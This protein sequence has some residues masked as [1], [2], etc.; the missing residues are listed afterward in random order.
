M[1]HF[2]LAVAVCVKPVTREHQD[3]GLTD[4]LVCLPRRVNCKSQSGAKTAR[5]GI[6]TI[7]QL[8]VA[9]NQSERPN[10]FYHVKALTTNNGEMLFRKLLYVLLGKSTVSF[11]L[12]V[13]MGLNARGLEENLWQLSALPIDSQNDSEGWATTSLV[14]KDRH[15]EYIIHWKGEGVDG[16]SLQFRHLEFRGALSAVL[17]TSVVD[18][19]FEDALDYTGSVELQASKLVQFNSAMQYIHIPRNI[20]R[21][22]LVE[23]A[24]RCSLIHALYDIV[25][26][27][28]A[29]PPLASSA[30]QNNGFGDMYSGSQN[31]EATWCVRVRR[32]G[33]SLCSEK[34]KRY[35]ARARS[36]KLEKEALKA[37][38]PLLLQFGGKVNLN[39]PDCKIYIFDGL[40]RTDKVLARRI[41]SGP[42]VSAIAPNTRI[43]VTNTPLCPVAAFLLCNVAGIRKIVS[44][45][46]PYVGSGAILLAAAMIQ[47]SCRSVGIEIAD[48]GYVNRDDILLDFDTRNLTRPLALLHGDSTNELM[49]EEAKK[50][51]GNDAFDLIITD[52][53]YGIRESSNY[54]TL[55]PAEELFQSIAKDRDLGRRLLKKG[56]RLVCFVPC[57]EDENLEDVLP[58][59]EQAESAGLQCEVVR[60]QPLNDSLSR[61]L[62]SYLCV[63]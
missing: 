7:M 35:G 4:G 54:N 50:A 62:V 37:L 31:E 18:V 55:T 6:Q 19:A 40:V 14:E 59:R 20:H 45:L 9:S 51:I 15:P 39:S 34:E 11:V 5:N 44:I 56:G 23:A 32:F 21:K 16:Y 2:F 12:R 24:E 38:E 8:L 43:C 46:D 58:S 13:P 33:Q 36:M 30:I 26:A 60:E 53:P 17:E 63:R 27:S 25:S 61:W 3:N 28:D 57:N 47:P 1:F 22:S 52:P 41:T 29:Y 49:R 42:R 48:N 10:I